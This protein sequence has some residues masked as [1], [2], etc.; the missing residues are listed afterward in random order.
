M[1]RASSYGILAINADAIFRCGLLLLLRFTSPPL[2]LLPDDDPHLLICAVDAA[3][4]ST[5]INDSC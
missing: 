2:D 1:W 4:A 3:N 5:R